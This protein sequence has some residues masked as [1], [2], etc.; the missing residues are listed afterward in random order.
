MRAKKQLST[1]RVE[2]RVTKQQKQSLSALARKKGCTGMTG[3]LK[4]LA[5][6]KKVEIKV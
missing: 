3:L 1:E 5:K 2:A 4:L 6:A